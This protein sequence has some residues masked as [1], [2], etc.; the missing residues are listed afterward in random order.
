V[1]YRSLA[2]RLL[3]GAL[4][5]PGPAGR[6]TGIAGGLAL[7]VVLH[8]AIACAIGVVASVLGDAIGFVGG[9]LL[10]PHFLD[11][12]GHWV[13]YTR[14][15]R[16]RLEQLYRQWGGMTLI[17]TRS[18]I[19]YIGVLASILAGAGRYPFV[20]FFIYSVVGRLIWTA[21]YF[22]SGYGVGTDFEVASGFLGYVSLLL[23]SLAIAF[24]A[25]TLWFRHRDGAS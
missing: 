15:N 21:S 10:S 25:G 12:W 3:L 20:R 24:G 16:L 18:L 6:L 1:G 4:G 2:V 7:Q 19:A 14:A 8:W 5:L 23:I 22:G 17:L 13:G 9:R 11:R